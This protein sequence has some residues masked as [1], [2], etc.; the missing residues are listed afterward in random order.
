MAQQEIPLGTSMPMADEAMPRAEGGQA[1]LSSLAGSTGTVV[2]FW[3]NQCP[4]TDK[5]E[6]RVMGL[7][8]AYQG[9]NLRF[10][11]VN[12]NDEAAFPQ[13]SAASSAEQGYPMPYLMDK[14]SALANAFGASR[15]P[16]VFVFDADRS[17]VYAG[18][19][20]DSP[21]DPGNVKSTY[22][23]DALSA[24]VSGQPIP[25][26]KTKAFGCTIKFASN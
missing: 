14:S 20:D 9:Q 26:A 10:V 19:I 15:A 23:D 13:E 17:L 3:S 22:L 5:Y 16:H 1:T 12:S 24:L 6:D 2:I 11:L 4:W 8:D 21:G 18:T 7:H 25:V